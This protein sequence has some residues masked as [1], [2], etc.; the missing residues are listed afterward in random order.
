MIFPSSE[1]ASKSAQP[2]KKMKFDK[3]ITTHQWGN[4]PTK[5]EY[6]SSTGFV[7]S[8]GTYS[9]S[10]KFF[11]D[12]AA[13]AKRDFPELKDEDIQ[14]FI[15]TRSTYN[16]GFAGIRFPIPENTKKDGYRQ[17]KALDFIHC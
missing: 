6:T 5:D 11:N 8:A 4:N 1:I 16:E 2:I 7:I 10:L 17:V 15:I 13:E 3:R 9:H 14:A 12:A